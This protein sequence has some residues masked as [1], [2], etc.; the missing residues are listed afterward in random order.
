MDKFKLQ[1]NWNQDE[2]EQWAMAARQKEEDA[3]IIRHVRGTFSG[4]Q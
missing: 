1:M 4:P 2:M 3:I